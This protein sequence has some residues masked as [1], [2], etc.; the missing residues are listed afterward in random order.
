MSL[1]ES[2]HLSNTIS[3]SWFLCRLKKLRDSILTI[4]MVF[5]TF[6]A[7][8]R[9]L[10]PSSSKINE[11]KKHFYG[12]LPEHLLNIGAID[13]S[14]KVLDENGQPIP[15]ASILIKGTKIATQTDVNGQ[16]QLKDIADDAVLVIS[17]V[18]Y[19]T[20][21]VKASSGMTIKLIPQS[22]L[23]EVVIVGYGS[24]KKSTLTGSVSSIKMDKVN[25]IPV[26]NLSNAMAGRAPGITVTNTSGL[27][28]ATSSIRIRGSFREPLYVINGVIKNKASFDALDP[29]EIDQMSILKDAAS[30]S[31]YGAQ[32]GNG[33][34]VVTTKTGKVQAPQF[35]FQVSNT[36]SKSTQR[37]L[38]DITTAADE[39]TYQNRVTRFEW[40]QGA[41][42]TPYVQPNNE[43]EFSYF[44]DKIYNVNDYV[45]RN[46]NSQKYLFSVN[47]GSEKI[48]YYT[49]ASY[50]NEQGTYKNVDFGK[51]N[52]R[53]DVTAQLNKTL[54]LNLNLSASQQNNNRFFWQG[55]GADDFNVG[56]FYR[57]TFN[58]TKLYPFYTQADGTP[59][60]GVT[61]FPVQTPLGSF[62]AWS[63]I[64]QVNGD[65]Y[66]DTKNRQFNPILSLNANLDAITK[67]LSAKIVGNYEAVDYMR[68]TF[69]TYQKNFV[70]IPKEPTG[71]RFIPAAP[72]PQRTNTY[73]FGQT[74]PS[75]SYQMNNAW[76]YQING[77]LN[78]NRSFGK[79][80]VN[81]QAIFEQSEFKTTFITTTGFAPTASIDQMFAYSNSA[82]N[83]TGNATENIGINGGNAFN[84]W[85]SNIAY[86]GKAGYNYDEK[87]LLDFS[88]RYDGTPL[89]AEDKRWGFFPSVSAGWRISQES[90]VRDNVKWLSDLKLRA[91][92]GT[93]GNLVNTG[94]EVIAPFGFEQTYGNG[95]QYIFGNTLLRG[96]APGNIPN[97]NQTWATIYNYNAGLDFGFLNQKLTG[98]ADF[99]LNNMKN[100]L[101]TRVITL[102][103]SYGQSIAPEN[104][105]ARSFRGIDFNLQ[106]QDKIGEVSYS[107]FG[108]VGYAKDRWDILDQSADYRP[109]GVNEWRSAIG[110]PS[111][112]IIGLKAIDLIRTQEQ[113]DALNAQ[114]FLQYGRKPYL[115]AILF[116]DI[117]GDSFAPG[118]NNKIDD[119]DLQVLS[120]NG[121]PRINFGFG[122]R[123]NWRGITVDALMQGVGAYDRMISN[124]EGGGMRQHGGN[125]R[126]YYPIWAGDVWTAENPNAKYPRP[127]GQNWA[128]SGASTSSFWLVNGAYLRLRNINIDYDLPQK[129]ISK[130]GLS[131]TQL[132]FNGTNLLTFSAMKEFQDPEQ[133][134]YDSFPIMK[135]FTLGLNVKF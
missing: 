6:Q 3:V 52:L 99:F 33:V 62:Q 14:G 106:W 22:D 85:V 68:K 13:V 126:T 122:F 117:R 135:T 97:P 51:F 83:R 28:G 37:L 82:G 131:G 2:H 26:S 27:A 114:G 69:I 56:D 61:N 71:N 133:N 116:E 72:D 25:D 125:F 84:S 76:R 75:L 15:S 11:E 21:E 110:Q 108:N 121:A 46:P 107:I 10:A 128:E 38:G 74:Q 20:Q 67:G 18:G 44:N 81:A 92:Y 96:I 65:R 5:A 48:T 104:Y 93:T 60:D 8:A 66:I 49:M 58:W 123:V 16:F 32:A 57:V 1:F 64:D 39:L 12:T 87:Y 113:L 115:G 119:N 98:S 103:A 42:T 86:I 112:R 100:I 30:A 34:V 19:K 94:N 36:L 35:N 29:N 63:V 91:S 31:I 40:E 105:A 17:Y 118:A 7:N 109:G 73:T 111:N 45:W 120:T 124:Q 95:N 43:R 79:H 55:D 102:P 77:F 9:V 50:T 132:F 70:F 134:N 41:R 80:Q 130:V 4:V 24:Q 54:S 129:W 88:F 59:A 90:F 53:S 127:V 47:G 89:V 101:G 23:D 78:Y